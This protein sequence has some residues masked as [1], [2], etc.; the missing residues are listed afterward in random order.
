MAV[1]AGTRLQISEERWKNVA[2]RSR[3]RLRTA[4]ANVVK[5]RYDGAREVEY[6]RNEH[7]RLG[8]WRPMPGSIRSHD[9][10]VVAVS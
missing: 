2:S 8:K 3:V 10:A 7:F 6:E 5:L 9:L 4:V 1:G